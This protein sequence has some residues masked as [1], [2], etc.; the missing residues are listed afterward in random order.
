M[1]DFTRWLYLRDK[2]YANMTASER[3]EW[4]TDMKGSYNAS[5]LN[6]VGAVL[7]YLR[8]R[9]TEAAYLTGKEFSMRENW[10]KTEI[11]E[12]SEFRAYINA[13]E[14]I[15]GAMSQKLTTPPTPENNGSLDYQGANNI[16]QILLD[17]DELI[18]NMLKSR[19]FIGELFSGEI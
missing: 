18:T 16:E 7:N 1:S 3:E 2:G 15:R 12:V 6:R 19:Y 13:V 11:P 5:D 9:L 14:T 4:A 10:Q 17:I 8:D